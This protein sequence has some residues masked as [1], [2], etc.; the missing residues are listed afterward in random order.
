MVCFIVD[1]I[2]TSQ[3]KTFSFY[4]ADK[5]V[6]TTDGG[7]FDVNIPQR[8]RTAVY[9]T[10]EVNEVRRCS[11]FYKGIDFRLIP[12]EEHVAEQLEEEYR[13]AAHTGEWRRKIPLTSGETVVFNGPSD[14]LHFLQ[15]QSADSWNDSLV[16]CLI[17]RYISLADDDLVED[18]NRIASFNSKP[19]RKLDRE[20]LSEELMNS[21][22]KMVNPNKSIIYCSWCMELGVRAI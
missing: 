16:S 2:L 13:D 19:A 9:W 20:R 8:T 14:I 10:A 17:V 7:R 3:I 5:E 6:V 18:S 12:Y 11:W 15:S 21:Q 22:S 4:I 1:F